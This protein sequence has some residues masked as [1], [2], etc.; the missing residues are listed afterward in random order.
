MMG[1]FNAVMRVVSSLIG[2]VVLGTGVIWILQG[3]NLAFRVGF[4]VGQP[5]WVFFGAILALVGVAHIIWS[6]VRQTRAA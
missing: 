1:T 6:N 2:L 4:M 5:R 3:L